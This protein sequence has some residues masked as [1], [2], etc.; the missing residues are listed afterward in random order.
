MQNK[1]F[2][3]PDCGASNPIGF[4]FCAKCGK[5]F[6][7]SCPDC[8]TEITPDSKF[9]KTCGAELIW[10]I[11]SRPAYTNMGPTQRA[12]VRPVQVRIVGAPLQKTPSKEPA[13]A[14]NRKFNAVPWIIVFILI[15]ITIVLLLN[16][17]SLFSLFK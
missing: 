8:N 17:D 3:C 4:S 6:S 13:P 7:Y 5:K 10:N 11:P 9:C 2:S 1:E 16:S 15:I 12:P 14:A